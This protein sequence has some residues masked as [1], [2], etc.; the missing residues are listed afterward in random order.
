MMESNRRFKI[1][2]KKNDTE[3]TII[4]NLLDA[5]KSSS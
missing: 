3:N 5:S 1:T 4:Q 2:L